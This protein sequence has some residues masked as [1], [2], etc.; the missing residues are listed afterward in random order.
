MMT[1]M[2][3]VL[4]VAERS[5]GKRGFATANSGRKRVGEVV[6]Q[7][8]TTQPTPENA[9]ARLARLVHSNERLLAELAV[10]DARLVEAEVYLAMASSNLGLARA[11][12]ARTKRQRSRVLAML[13]ANRIEAREFLSQ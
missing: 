10:L 1:A 8:G 9:F 6:E 7:G 11:Y 12:R 2:G 3:S 13:R 5:V 4:S